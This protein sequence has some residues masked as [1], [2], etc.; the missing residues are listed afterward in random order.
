MG[1]RGSTEVNFT[2][3]VSK[4]EDKTMRRDKDS[5]GKTKFTSGNKFGK[6]K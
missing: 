3:G 1:E 6:R 5:K 4:M 2:Y